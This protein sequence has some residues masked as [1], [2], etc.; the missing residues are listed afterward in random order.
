MDDYAGD[1]N[2]NQARMHPPLATIWTEN[3]RFDVDLTH[4]VLV[5][6]SQMSSILMLAV[7]S[8]VCIHFIGASAEVVSHAEN[9][10]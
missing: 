8:H 5:S 6:S 2:D 3:S 10:V 4:M 9:C 7:L 1:D